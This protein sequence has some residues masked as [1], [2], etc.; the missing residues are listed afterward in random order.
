MR[1]DGDW[2]TCQITW[3]QLLRSLPHAARRR[4]SSKLRNV[5]LCIFANITVICCLLQSM[6]NWKVLRN[7]SNKSCYCVCES[8]RSGCDRLHCRWSCK[9]ITGLPPSSDA[10]P[11]YHRWSSSSVYSTFPARVIDCQLI[12]VIL[13]HSIIWND[14]RPRPTQEF[15]YGMDRKETPIKLKQ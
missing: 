8:G 15:I 11:L 1:N 7:H 6:L 14:S 2:S 4:R 10:P 13:H 5:E 9:L 3:P 12:L